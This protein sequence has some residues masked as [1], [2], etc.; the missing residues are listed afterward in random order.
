MV[1]MSNICDKLFQ[2]LTVVLEQM[3]VLFLNLALVATL[4]NGVKLLDCTSLNEGILGNIY[5]DESS[6]FPKS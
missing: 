4:F 6:K 5:M 2:I 1:I 3:S